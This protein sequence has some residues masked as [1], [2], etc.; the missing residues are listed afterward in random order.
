MADPK[1]ENSMIGIPVLILQFIPSHDGNIP[2]VHWSAP[3]GAGHQAA[4][5]R[6]GVA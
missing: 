2:R 6:R 1:K 3:H 5:N 4:A